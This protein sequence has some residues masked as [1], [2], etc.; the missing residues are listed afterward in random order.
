MNWF[1]VNATRI[2]MECSPSLVNS[3]DEVLLL[4]STPKFEGVGRKTMLLGSYAIQHSGSSKEKK[5]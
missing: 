3:I 4:R 1:T 5:T 2:A